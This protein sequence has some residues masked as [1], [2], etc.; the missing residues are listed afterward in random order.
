MTRHRVLEDR[1]RLTE[2]RDCVMF[3]SSCVPGS[4]YQSSLQRTCKW[5]CD[6]RNLYVPDIGRRGDTDMRH[7][8]RRRHNRVT[9]R[10]PGTSIPRSQHGTD[11]RLYVPRTC[12]HWCKQPRCSRSAH[13][14]LSHLPIHWDIP[15]AV[16]VVRALF[17]NLFVHCLVLFS[18]STLF[19]YRRFSLLSF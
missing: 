3:R 19:C 9:S 13:A 14:L 7:M 6:V 15:D 1:G 11:T 18:I 4:V 10:A 12:H 16:I 8:D 5:Q 2:T 17:N